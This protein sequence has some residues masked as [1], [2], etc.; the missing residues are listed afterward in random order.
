MS[1][2]IEMNKPNKKI[3]IIGAGII[4]TNCAYE[5]QRLGCDVTLFDR[6]GIGEK[7]SKGN[8][9]H[10][11]T[12]QVFPHASVE[13]LKQLPRLLISKTGPL[14]ISLLHLL[15]AMPWFAQFVINARASKFNSNKQALKQLN[16]HAIRHYKTLLKHINAEHLLTSEGSLLV[17]EHTPLADV[18]QIASKYLCENIS[19]E[20]LNKEQ[21]KSM[22]S[23][24]SD[25][26]TSAIHFTDVAHTINP[27]SLCQKIGHYVLENGG[28]LNHEN[29]RKIDMDNGFAT[30]C[31]EN[32]NYQFDQ[33]VIATGAWAKDLLKPL[34]YNVPMEAERGYHYQFSG[35]V[36]LK[37]PIVSAE[38][39]FIMTPMQDGLRCAGTAEFSGLNTQPNV[40]RAN[41]LKDQVK[42]L[43]NVPPDFFKPNKEQ[44]QWSGERP[45]FP[46]SLPAIGKAYKHNNLYIAIGHQHL[47]LT[48][49]A[50]TGKLIGQVMTGEKTEVDLSSFCLSRFN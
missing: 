42:H 40:K 17:F 47:G 39:Q 26:I 11:A 24:L 25:N 43:L 13:T 2:E 20:I 49:G 44:H 10:F 34:G 32:N 28:T 30:I 5:L 22:E 35:H 23:D 4:G 21:C 41:M 7:C 12:E 3:A 16:R 15:K 19:L 37:R 6:T 8:A 27:Y 50:I 48:L 18:E 1:I 14:S 33:V 36:S 29:V 45:S 31:T 9:G 38:R 46:D